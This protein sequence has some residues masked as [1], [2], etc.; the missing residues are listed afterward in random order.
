MTDDLLVAAAWE[1]CATL[2]GAAVDPGALG[3]LGPEW[4]PATVP[5]TAAGAMRD[6][7]RDYDERDYDASD[8]WFRCHFAAPKEGGPWVLH[9]GGLA[10]IA[11]VWLNDHHLLHT[12]NMFLRHDIEVL[13]LA[14]E[15]E[16]VIRCASLVPW[17]A[18]K[19]PRPRWK[20][21]LVSHQ[22][23]RWLRTTLL[24]RLP[25][26]AVTPAP[27]GPWRPVTLRPDV[28]RIVE[29]RV[30]ARCDGDDG[31]VDVAL[32]LRGS[33]ATA[34]LRVGDLRGELTVRSDG[35]DTVVEGSLR[36]PGVERWWPHT[37]GPQP[38]YE[39]AIEVPGGELPL[40]RIGF[41]TI[42]VD[43]ADG[44]FRLRVN[45]VPVFCRGATWMP[46]DPVAMSCPPRAVR[47]TLELLRHAH[48]NMVRVPGT[49]VYQDDEFFDACDELG[50]L[51]WQDCM[52]AFVDHPDEAAFVA[53]VQEELG[54]V[55]SALGGRPSVGVVCG[56]QEISEQAAMLALRRDKWT[57]PLIEQHIPAVVADAL[58]GVPYVTDNPSGGGVP[59]QMNAGVSHYFGIG[60]YIRPVQDAR[61]AEVRFATECLAFATPPEPQTIDEA[62]GG[63]TPCRP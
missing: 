58:P 16:L 44:A 49:G 52:F 57:F 46:V 9:L 8:W 7:G 63:I 17:L 54:Q 37:H 30:V 19:R 39:A 4:S 12:E 45:D 62:C 22:N 32:R 3:V 26:W 50:I 48:M 25:G 53:L 13:A 2:P 38:L 14:D 10:T 5:G 24:G 40:G 23:L 15:N 36:V 1:C 42:D 33:V 59:F 31:V 28:V 6:A 34:A 55:L 41:R 61:R 18:L 60:G 27:V 20:T 56:G 11:D 47:D 43:R 21:Y 51:V 35:G 29:R